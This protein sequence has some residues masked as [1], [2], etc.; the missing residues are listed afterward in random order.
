MAEM[1]TETNPKTDAADTLSEDVISLAIN[2][3][4]GIVTDATEV[5]TVAVE[6]T[7]SRQIQ[8]EDDSNIVDGAEIVETK[9]VEDEV[10]V[11][12]EGPVTGQTED[13]VKTEENPATVAAEEVVEVESKDVVKAETEEEEVE[14]D[15]ASDTT[16]S[17]EPSN[18]EG[19]QTAEPPSVTANPHTESQ[20]SEQQK[21]EVTPMINKGKTDTR[22]VNEAASAPSKDPEIEKKVNLESL[23]YGE[24]GKPTEV[25]PKPVYKVDNDL[26]SMMKSSSTKLKSF[27][28]SKLRGK[29]KEGMT[30]ETAPSTAPKTEE[31]V[32]S[33]TSITPKRLNIRDWWSPPGGQ[34]YEYEDLVSLNI[35]KEYGNLQGNSLESY[36]STADFEQVFGMKRVSHHFL[37]LFYLQGP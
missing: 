12:V 8:F 13:V 33:G 35:S 10:E 9:I 4:D 2:A 11:I 19:S 36:L 15:Q 30:V 3:S 21:A 37:S 16:S 6:S 27:D 31:L 23:R 18:I 29:K 17:A 28:Y 7:L 1:A 20:S 5:S 26:L 34:Y 25:A 14:V 22:K 32:S 24:K